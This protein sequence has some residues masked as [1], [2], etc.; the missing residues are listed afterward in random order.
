MDACQHVR[1]GA[2]WF[3]PGRAGRY[4]LATCM[5]PPGD[6]TMPECAMPSDFPSAQAATRHRAR[7]AGACRRCPRPN[8]CPYLER[9]KVRACSPCMHAS[10]TFIHACM[11]GG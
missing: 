10:P 1:C 3:Q 6:T 4:A 7:L 8:Q 2:L 5:L 9:M 11:H